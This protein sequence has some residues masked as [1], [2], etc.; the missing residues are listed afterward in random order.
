MCF[1]LFQE[2][3]SSSTYGSNSR[4]S[5]VRIKHLPPGTVKFET[6]VEE[7]LSGVVTKEPPSSWGSRSPTKNNS[8]VI[9]QITKTCR[10]KVFGTVGS[11]YFKNFKTS[12]SFILLI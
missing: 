4:Q 2:P 7:G 5:A 10:N 6:L 9:C 11:N 1:D 3:N 8:L 12:E